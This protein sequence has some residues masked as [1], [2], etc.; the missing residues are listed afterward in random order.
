MA[1]QALG[2]FLSVT[3]IDN[4]NVKSVLKYK[5]ATSTYAT[6]LTDA[7]TVIAALEAFTNLQVK[8][9][10]VETRFYDDAFTAGAGNAKVKG[11]VSGVISGNPTK[12]ADYTVP[13]P[14]DAVLG[15]PGTR[16]Y[17]VIDTANS[18][19]SDYSA[20][21]QSGGKVKISDGEVLGNVTGGK[22]VTRGSTN[23]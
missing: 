13:D 8:G 10:A 4:S 23:P 11:V 9:Y 6:A 5:F 12:S 7:G 17:N 1:I 21:F 16:G 3:V 2:L 20:L 19:V 14:V 22:R 15:T 18:I